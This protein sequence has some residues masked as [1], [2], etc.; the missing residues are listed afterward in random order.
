MDR[1]FVGDPDFLLSTLL[2]SWLLFLAAFLAVRRPQPQRSQAKLIG[3]TSKP[4]HTPN[5]LDDSP[6]P[7][8]CLRYSFRAETQPSSP[9]VPL[10]AEARSLCKKFQVDPVKGFLGEEDPLL[11]LS[12]PELHVWEDVVADLP[13]LLVSGRARDVLGALP[14]LSIEGIKGAREQRR[15]LLVLSMLCHAWVWGKPSEPQETI[16]EGIAVPLWE[17]AGHLG[18]PPVMTHMSLV[19]YNWRRLDPQGP[20]ALENLGTACQFLGGLDEAWFYLVTVEIEAKGGAA[21]A[22]LLE[23]LEVIRRATTEGAEACV[24]VGRV[25]KA[26]KGSIDAMRAT[27]SRMPEG[28]DPRTFY[29]RVRPFL[30]GWKANPTLPHGVRYDGVGK[31]RYQF[32]GGSAA[33]SSLFAALD[34][35]L[36]VDHARRSSSGFLK[37]MLGYMPPGHRE[38]LRHLTSDGQP[39]IR[40]FVVS[41]ADNAGREGAALQQAYNKAS[42]VQ[43][44]P[45]QHLVTGH[46]R[47][48]HP[49]HSSLQALQS[50]ESFR[51]THLGIV[52]AYIIQQQRKADGG[53]YSQDQAAGG[54][55]TGGTPLLEFLRPL[56]E[57]VREAA[58]A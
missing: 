22:P 46:T 2:L 24:T 35:A 50:L 13:S 16:P 3:S 26:V 44:Y 9:L 47:S 45:N 40:E 30:S 10:S 7:A 33:Q 58:M 32:Y 53:E 41:M 15:A 38:F 51:T 28:C 37:D 49:I 20:I 43:G 54:K 29:H 21:M 14:V 42:N 23:A 39:R 52:T 55:G 19:L 1:T 31:E 11:R 57:D 12:S 56:R 25:L 36:G 8:S 6:E 4:S 17:L 5:S 48:S 18:V 27:L 34:A